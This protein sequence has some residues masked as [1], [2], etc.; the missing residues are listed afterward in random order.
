MYVL[1][2]LKWFPRSKLTDKYRRKIDVIQEYI[3]NNL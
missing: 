3:I 2:D 1:K